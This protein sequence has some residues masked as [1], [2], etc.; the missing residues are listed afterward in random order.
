MPIEQSPLA[1][2]HPH[3]ESIED[4]HLASTRNQLSA[5]YFADQR[6]WV[7]AYSGG[8]D[9]TA[10]LQLVYELVEHLRTSGR[11]IEKP[12][13]VISSDT[14][15]ESPNVARYVTDCLERIENAARK[16]GV[17]IYTRLVAPNA[18]ESFWGKLIGLG[19]LFET[20]ESA[21]NP[22]TSRG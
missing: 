11:K 3:S 7:I 10:V 22:T 1:T 19:Y 18:D 6:P 17:A 2:S 5:L 21:A 9:S 12:I 14:R 16:A 13:F 15:V 20:A 8:K 4:A